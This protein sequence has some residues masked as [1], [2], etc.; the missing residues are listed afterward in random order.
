MSK[1]PPSLLTAWLWHSCSARLETVRHDFGC[2]WAAE[3]PAL[4]QEE[5]QERDVWWWWA[6]NG[7]AAIFIPRQLKQVNWLLTCPISP[8]LQYGPRAVCRFLLSVY[9][10]MKLLLPGLCRCFLLTPQYF[11][12]CQIWAVFSVLSSNLIPESA[13]DL[14]FSE[15]LHLPATSGRYHLDGMPLTPGGAGLLINPERTAATV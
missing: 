7:S 2:V 14:T 15:P 5:W 6:D 1:T 3:E 13:H 8:S 4:I 11:S 9:L 10:W 12:Y